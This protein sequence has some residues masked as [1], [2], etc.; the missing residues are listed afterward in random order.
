MR[1]I[2]SMISGR[3]RVGRGWPLHLALLLTCLGIALPLWSPA[4]SAAAATNPFVGTSWFIDPNSNARQQATTWRTAQ[5]ADAAA[6]DMI[7]GQPQADWFGDFSGDVRAAVDARVGQ[8]TTTGA[9]PILV[10]YNLPNRDC[11]GYSGGGLTT[12]AA[13]LDWVR[14]FAAGIGARKAIVILEPDG[15]VVTDCLSPAQRQE[16]F[17]ALKGAV[18]IL[19]A[20]PGTDV[21]IAAGH[22]GWYTAEETASRLNAAGIAQA[23]GFALNAA[24]FR[25]SA[26]ELIYGRAIAERVGGKHFVIDTSRNGLG[27]VDGPNSW[28]N[29]TGQGLGHR[30]TVVTDDPYLDAYLWIKRPGESDG[31]CNGSPAAGQWWPEYALGLAQRAALNETVACFAET[32]QCA[33]GQFFAYW[34]AH[35][36]LAINGLPL[37]GVRLETLE[38]GKRYAVQYF[39]RTRL[40]YHPENAAPYDLLVGQ[41]G[42][43][44]VAGVSSA[45]TADAAPLAGAQFFPTT[46]HNVGTR[47]LAY[48]Q[49]NGGLAQFGYPLTEEFT[50]QL[51]NGQTYTVQYFERARFEYHPENAAPYDLLLGQFGRQIYA[52][53][54]AGEGR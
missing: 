43:R 44:V 48:W 47:F 34:Q 38:D 39:E 13:Y 40:E 37:S 54:T 4:P 10:A 31:A 33:G 26:N 19:K 30:P 9:L 27:P 8:I 24:N 1:K 11:G 25:P 14:A 18:A 7:A 45:P 23:D 53:V 46:R 22:S 16:R 41:F 15:L 5:P 17:D 20:Q 6:M 32:G 29:P 36:G 52:E 12:N 35:G 51:A 42:R 21:Y 50:Q 49:A 2:A 3:R 28:C